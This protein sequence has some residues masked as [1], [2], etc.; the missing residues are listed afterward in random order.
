MSAIDDGRPVAA[1]ERSRGISETLHRTARVTRMST[2][3]N[4]S[5][6][7]PGPHSTGRIGR[8]GLVLFVGTFLMPALLGVL[9]FGLIASDLYV[10]EMRFAVR[11]AATGAERAAPDAIGATLGIPQAMV[12]QDTLITSE[13]T[14]SRAIIE[15]VEKTL[16]SLRAMF[17]TPAADWFSRWDNEEPVEEF[18]KYWRHHV[19]S[20]V[21]KQSGVVLVKVSAFTA[22][23]SL[24]IAR[25]VLAAS[26]KMVNGLT[27]EARA[28][29]LAE[30]ETELRRIESRMSE[31]RS[32][33]RDLR[34]NE[35]TLDA[36]KSGEAALRVLSEVR[37][38]RIRTDIRLRMA[39]RDLNESSR[40]VKD[41]RTLLAEIDSKIRDM[42]QQMATTNVSAGRAL[43]ASLTRFEALDI[44]RQNAEKL[45]GQVLAAHERA[46]IIADRQVVF[47][48]AVVPPVL[49][50]SAQEPRRVLYSSLAVAGALL[51]YGAAV[52]LRAALR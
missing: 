42:E 2:N 24:A 32:A 31:I 22:E 36:Q 13:Y 40:Q 43:S 49:A 26:E 5:R 30:T 45:F 23:D 4:A 34:N 46:R 39:S 20:T 18:V 35:G 11:P 19:R 7:L 48:N 38:E 27:S 51:L 9:Y 17:A 8:V 50:E 37:L 47:F 33:M 29:A 3:R 21:D 1:L 16:P 6:P 52:G 25:A 10:T 15:E 14:Q 44:D 41:L 28:R 12:V